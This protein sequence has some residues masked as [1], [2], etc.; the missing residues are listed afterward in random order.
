MTAIPEHLLDAIW[1]ATEGDEAEAERLAQQWQR[2]LPEMEARA[3]RIRAQV[4]E[5]VC[6]CY[7]DPEFVTEDGRCGRCY[8]RR[9]AT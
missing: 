7:F 5:A 4:A 9:G 6:R 3:D 1:V 8:G 2:V